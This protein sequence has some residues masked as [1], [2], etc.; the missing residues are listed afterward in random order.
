MRCISRE[1]YIM[2]LKGKESKMTSY[3]TW[4]EKANSCSGEAV[5]SN[6]NDVLKTGTVNL[7]SSHLQTRKVK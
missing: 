5:F 2:Y 7:A 3:C 6:T 1:I 4:R